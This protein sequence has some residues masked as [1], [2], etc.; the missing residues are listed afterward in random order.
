MSD[1]STTRSSPARAGARRPAQRRPTLKTIADLT[2]LSVSTVSQSLR[3]LASLKLE[4]RQLIADTARQIGYVPDRAG[5]RLRTGRT[6]VITLVLSSRFHSGDFA[7]QMIAGVGEGVAGTNYHVNVVPDANDGDAST[8]RHI[9]SSDTADGLIITHTTPRDARVQL[10]IEAGFPFVAHGR[11]DFMAEHAFHDFHAEAFAQMAVERLVAL[12]CRRLM[13][14]QSATD[15]MNYRNIVSAFRAACDRAGVV[16]EA[17][18]EDF[19]SLGGYDNVRLF[20][21]RLAGRAD[22]PDG[23]VC[24]NEPYALAL[25]SGL[26][27]GGA[28]IGEEVKLVCKE[29][30]G[31]VPI[32]FPDA[33]GI[34][35]DVCAAGRELVRLLLHR[36]DGDR[37]LDMLQTYA[38][39][40]PRWRCPP[41]A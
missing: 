38:K 31:L 6:S 7:R 19:I 33:D 41:P 1:D 14:A 28:M 4:T 12:G 22:R 16:S 40:T 5:V 15:T 11:T 3:G 10:L 21:R 36:I 17:A 23:I 35:E 20:G 39:P 8:V 2:G 13:L 26:Q 29:T 25:G 27:S 32:V 34:Y 24:N 9:L 30:S 18:E 37:P